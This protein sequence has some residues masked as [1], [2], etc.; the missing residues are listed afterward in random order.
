[1]AK[2]VEMGCTDVIHESEIFGA[3]MPRNKPQ[4]EEEK[5]EDEEESSNG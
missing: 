4:D 3:A 5:S 2:I 1:M